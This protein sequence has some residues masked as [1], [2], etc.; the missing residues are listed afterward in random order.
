MIASLKVLYVFLALLGFDYHVRTY[1]GGFQGDSKRYLVIYAG[2]KEHNEEL[3]GFY[4]L[5]SN[6]LMPVLWMH[7]D[8]SWTIDVPLP[9]E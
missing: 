2:S 4:K 7:K 8:Q 5:L 9:V 3:Q 6:V 1:N